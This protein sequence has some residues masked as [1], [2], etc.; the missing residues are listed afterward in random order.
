M[1]N[2]TKKVINVCIILLQ[3]YYIHCLTI[4][5]FYSCIIFTGTSMTVL[6]MRAAIVHLRPPLCPVS[7]NMLGKHRLLFTLIALV[8]LLFIISSQKITNLDST[9]AFLSPM[10]SINLFHKM[11]V[12]LNFLSNTKDRVS[13]YLTIHPLFF[14]N[15]P[16][17]F[18]S[19]YFQVINLFQ[20]L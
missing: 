16:C 19:N 10:M 14:S 1:A 2:F 9:N 4:Q 6:D 3:Y 18:F 11:F 12:Y 7:D 13:F 20:V 5:L 8:L 15:I 17:Y